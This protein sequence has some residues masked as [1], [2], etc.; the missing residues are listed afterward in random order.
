[1]EKEKKQRKS[2]KI[3]RLIVAI[4]LILLQIAGIGLVGYTLMLFEGVET[5]YRIL[6]IA[7]LV[8]FFLFFSYRDTLT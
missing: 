8:Y 1:M 7:V 3:F 6:G 2:H 5:L 4:L